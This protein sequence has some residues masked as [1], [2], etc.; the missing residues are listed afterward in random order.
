MFFAFE[1]TN[2]RAF[3]PSFWLSRCCCYCCRALF[4]WIKLYRRKQE[5]NWKTIRAN[6]EWHTL[7]EARTK[8]PLED[9]GIIN[10]DVMYSYIPPLR[11]QNI[12][13]NANIFSIPLVTWRDVKAEAQTRKKPF[14]PSTPRWLNVV[15][16]FTSASR[17]RKMKTFRLR[18]LIFNYGEEFFEH[19]AM[20]FF[21]NEKPLFLKF[22]S[23][24]ELQNLFPS[25]NYVRLNVMDLSMH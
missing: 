6:Y 11:S 9:L 5:I 20:N 17:R 2:F 24:R 25:P 8:A 7:H 15:F 19:L 3:S 18:I 22:S 21:K 16:T 14:A 4:R 23:S 10:C 13:I 12:I 1:Q